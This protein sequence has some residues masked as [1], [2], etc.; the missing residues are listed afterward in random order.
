MVKYARIV[1][2]AEI[3]D[4]DSEDEIVDAIENMFTSFM[5]ERWGID[6]IEIHKRPYIVDECDSD[7]I[8]NRK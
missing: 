1:F 2:E 7:P 6:D 4:D 5:T 8:E 3:G